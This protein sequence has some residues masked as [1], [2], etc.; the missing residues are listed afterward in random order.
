[1]TSLV[2]AVRAQVLGLIARRFAGSGPYAGLALLPD[3]VLW[4]LHRDGLDPIE[5]MAELRGTAPVSRLSVPFGIR[6]WLVTGY[7]PVR[8]VLGSL[9]GYSNDFGKFAGKVGIN[10]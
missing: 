2:S 1:M 7:E 8:E 10:V 4:P 5:K 9:D 6:A 3:S